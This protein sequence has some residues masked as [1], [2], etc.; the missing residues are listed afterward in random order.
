MM[1]KIEKKPFG[2]NGQASGSLFKEFAET[3]GQLNIG[4]SFLL[5]IERLVPSWRMGMTAIGYASGRRFASKTEKA[6][7]IRIGRIA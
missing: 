1:L 7:G 6:G 2:A 3:C 4:E 5:P